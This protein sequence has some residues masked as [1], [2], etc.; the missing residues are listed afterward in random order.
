MIQFASRWLSMTSNFGQREMTVCL[1][2][3]LKS[4]KSSAG[5]LHTSRT[6]RLLRDC[7]GLSGIFGKMSSGTYF[8]IPERFCLIFLNFFSRSRAVFKVAKFREKTL[9]KKP[10]PAPRPT[11]RPQPKPQKNIP[12][13]QP[14]Q[15]VQNVPQNLQQPSQNNYNKNNREIF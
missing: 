14:V 9:S 3:I 7:W 12:K 5:L 13:P 10:Q 2:G 1:Y 8:Y 15:S 4:T 6:S 11:Q